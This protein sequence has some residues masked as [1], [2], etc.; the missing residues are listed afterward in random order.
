MSPHVVCVPFPTQGHINPM[1]KL[2]KLLHHKGFHVTFVNTDYNHRRLLRSRGPDSLD[3][4]RTSALKPSP[5]ASHLLTPM[6]AKT[7][8]LLSIPPPRIALSHFATFSTNSTT[9]PLPTCRL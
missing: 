7:S 3:A 6:S 9:L 4:C 5:T 1:L 2:A 8:P